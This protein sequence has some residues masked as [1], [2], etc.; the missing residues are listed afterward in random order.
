MNAYELAKAFAEELNSNLTPEQID[1]VN[2]LNVEE[3]DKAICHSHDFTDANQLMI[4]AMGDDYERMEVLKEKQPH[5]TEEEA[6]ELESLWALINEA[7]AIAKS[8]EFSPTMI[9]N[10]ERGMGERC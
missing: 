10:D 4:D 1:E 8:N 7:W 2:R 5:L 6:A 9:E 3:A